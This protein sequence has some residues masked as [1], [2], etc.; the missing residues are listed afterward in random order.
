M[1]VWCTQ[2]APRQQQFHVPPAM[3]LEKKGEEKKE[4][5]NNPVSYSHSFKITCNKSA[6]S[7]L[8]S[9]E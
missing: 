2:N 9:G 4:K 5:N 1:V 7:S 6:V 3:S 8:E